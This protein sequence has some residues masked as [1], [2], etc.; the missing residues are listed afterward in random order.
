MRK[1]TPNFS[2]GEFLR[3]ADHKHYMEGFMEA[4]GKYLELIEKLYDYLGQAHAGYLVDDF[5]EEN[6]L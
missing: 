3:E 1:I 4:E 2:R 5:K 6:G